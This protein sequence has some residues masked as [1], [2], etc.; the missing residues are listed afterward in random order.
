MH[1]IVS[2]GFRRDTIERLHI[3]ETVNQAFFMKFHHVGRYSAQCVRRLNAA[4]EHF[5]PYKFDRRKRGSPGTC[6]Y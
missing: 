4:P 6:L 5:L 3:Y 2:Q 1:L